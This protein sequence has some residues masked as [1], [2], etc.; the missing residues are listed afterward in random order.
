VLENQHGSLLACG[1]LVSLL[2]GSASFPSNALQENVIQVVNE[3]GKIISAVLCIPLIPI[4][5]FN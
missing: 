1:Y 2:L 4:I 3:A 5:F